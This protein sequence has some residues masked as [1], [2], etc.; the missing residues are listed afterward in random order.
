M[1]LLFSRLPGSLW[2]SRYSC[3]ISS[4]IFPVLHA[5]YPIAQKCFPQYRRFNSGYSCCNNREVRPFIRFTKSEID[6]DGGYSIC[7]CTWSLLTTP[8]SILTS[9]VSQICT[10]KSRHLTLISPCSTWY[11]YLVTHTICAVS[12]VTLW[13]LWRFSLTAKLLTSVEMCSN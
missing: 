2:C 13:L 3:T 6:F 9:S 4:V 11:R 12:L 1:N 7:I 5:P 8:L 10:I